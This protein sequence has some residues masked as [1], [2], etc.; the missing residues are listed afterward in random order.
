MQEVLPGTVL[1]NGVQ[2]TLLQESCEYKK[3][4]EN[5]VNE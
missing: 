5:F 4:L 1:T 2:S 3:I